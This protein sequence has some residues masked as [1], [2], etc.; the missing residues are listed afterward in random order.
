MNTIPIVYS[1]EYLADLKGHVF[2]IEKYRLIVERLE[3]EGIL[4]EVVEPEPATRAN[5]WTTS[6][7]PAGRRAPPPPRWL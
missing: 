4:G 1:S 5:T 2:P 3:E 7:R 6:P